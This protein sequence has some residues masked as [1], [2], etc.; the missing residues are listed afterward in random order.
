MIKVSNCLRLYIA[1]GI[2]S[3][4]HKVSVK[5]PE[6]R[7]SKCCASMTDP[8]EAM[9]RTFCYQMESDKCLRNGKRTWVNRMSEMQAFKVHLLIAFSNFDLS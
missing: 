2:F 3:T 6:V 9:I 8:F 7:Y 1:Y 5:C 4:N